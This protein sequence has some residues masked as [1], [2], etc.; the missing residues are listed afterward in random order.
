MA[1]EFPDTTIDEEPSEH[2]DEV[3]IE[4]SAEEKKPETALDQSKDGVK[5]AVDEVAESASVGSAADGTEGSDGLEEPAVDSKGAPSL[6]MKAWFTGAVDKMSGFLGYGKRPLAITGLLIVT[7]ILS[8][9]YAGNVN[10]RLAEQQQEFSELQ[11]ELKS[12]QKEANALRSSNDSLRD[13][14]AVLNEELSEYKDQQATIDDEKAKLEELH[15]QYDSLEQERD[16]LV[17]QLDAKRLAEEQAA[18]EAERQRLEALES[19]GGGYSSGSNVGQTVYWVSGGSVY[20]TTPNCVTL[21]RSSNIQSGSISE[22]GK[23]RCCKVCG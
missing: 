9:L 12:S 7:L 4:G 13:H 11:G 18:R 14:V 20:H 8:S 6:G 1:E 21:K 10:T 19:S 3:M 16:E 22:S 23:G 2:V 17:R 5:D 15:A